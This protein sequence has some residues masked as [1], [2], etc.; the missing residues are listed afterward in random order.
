M[1]FHLAENIVGGLIITG[2]VWIAMF[3]WSVYRVYV[4]TLPDEANSRPLPM[5]PLPTSRTDTKTAPSPQVKLIFKDS[6]FFTAARRRHITMQI[7][8]FRNYL[9]GIGFDIPKEIPPIG[10]GHG[11]SGV[12]GSGDVLNSS[13]DIDDRRIDDPMFVRLPYAD[14]VFDLLLKVN[15]RSSIGW[16]FRGQVSHV[17]ATYYNLSYSGNMFELNGHAVPMRS[18]SWDSALWD[19]RSACGKDFT[20]RSMFFMFKQI[21]LVSSDPKFY[22]DPDPRAN[23]G[24]STQESNEYIFTGLMAGEG[25][26]DNN[27]QKR[28]MIGRILKEHGLID[29]Q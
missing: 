14:F 21:D 29:K 17:M 15:D 16:A 23:W 28:P 2:T 8:E 13:I 22:R 10:T 26:V 11:A 9:M 6:P 1:K 27:F 24:I 3:G 20:D 4:P 18:D 19:I 12:G 7:D 5:P 25:V